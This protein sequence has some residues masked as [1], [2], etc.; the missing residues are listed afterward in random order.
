M[1]SESP[2]M[3]FQDVATDKSL[4]KK[5]STFLKCVG[6][7]A[8]KGLNVPA[9]VMASQVISIM[10]MELDDIRILQMLFSYFDREAI[11]PIPR[12]RA[13]SRLADIKGEL[14]IIIK[15]NP[16]STYLDIGCG[17][18][19]ITAE[20]AKTL[21]CSG[22]ACACDLPGVHFR[23]ENSDY[24]SFSECSSTHLPYNTNS[25]DLIT[26]FMSAHH[27]VDVDAMFRET[28][29]VARP[30]SFLLMRE[31]GVADVMY[32]DIMHALYGCTNFAATGAAV[33]ITPAQFMALY[34]SPEKYAR[35]ACYDEWIDIAKQHGFVLVLKP[36]FNARDTLFN[37]VYM[38]FRLRKRK[39]RA[40]KP[41][42]PQHVAK[43]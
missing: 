38:L 10:S 5:L 15:N 27:F 41:N 26:M 19:E 33:E 32:Y 37:S 8:A 23:N 7:N 17:N 39:R 4:R 30:G 12:K 14:G 25:F 1:H 29:R 40:V 9:D 20:I 24:I 6:K 13:S 16:P 35:Y 11:G 28:R 2:L 31:H 3:L 34:N 21:G 18:C 43:H 42:N 22:G 36:R